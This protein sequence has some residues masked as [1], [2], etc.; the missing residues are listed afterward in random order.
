MRD[1]SSGWKSVLRLVEMFMVS[2]PPA[3]ALRE[4][5]QFGGAFGDCF[6]RIARE[7]ENPRLGG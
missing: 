1:T 3:S 2:Q 6:V 4:T 5:P 7:E